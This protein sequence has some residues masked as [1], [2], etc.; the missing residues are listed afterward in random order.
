MQDGSPGRGRRRMA[1]GT[2]EAMWSPKMAE[3]ICGRVAAGE[4]LAAICKD[5]AM[6]HR[7]SVRNWRLRDEAFDRAFR[8]ARRTARLAEAGEQ[9]RRRAVVVTRM[10]SARRGR[11]GRPAIYTPELAQQ[12][13]AR[14]A[15]G[16]SLAAICARAGMPKVAT[17]YS[18]LRKDVAFADMYAEAREIQADLKFDL[19][20]EVARRATPET[21]AVARLAFD[22]I[23]WQAAR[24]APKRYGERLGD[25]APARAALTVV[26]RRFGDEGEE[27][28]EPLPGYAR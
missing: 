10:A 7:T 16:E 5:P 23:R 20:W 6:P 27:V 21:V 8:A 18:W 9:A 12:V 14:L 15:M 17:V 3:A 28:L 2:F 22:V 19:A 24:L 13:C 26:I 1:D 25:L 4:S 11:G